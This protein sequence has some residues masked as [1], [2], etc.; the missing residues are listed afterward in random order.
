MSIAIIL[1][2]VAVVILGAIVVY[3]AAKVNRLEQS[4]LSMAV[5]LQAKTNFTS[6]NPVDLVRKAFSHENT[7]ET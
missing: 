4:F 6:D 1:M 5:I 2:G 7:N 3:L